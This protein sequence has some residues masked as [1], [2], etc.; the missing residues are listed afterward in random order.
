MKAKPRKPKTAKK[1]P[2]AADGHAAIEDWIKHVKADMRPIA[3]RV[4]ELV[5]RTIPGL[6]YAI[7]WRVPFYGLPEQGWII[8]IA[9][10]TSHVDVTFFGGADFDPPPPHGPV[11]RRDRYVKVKTLEE[12]QGPLMRKWIKQAGRVRGWVMRVHEAKTRLP[13]RSNRGSATRH[14][15]AR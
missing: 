2:G 3:Q 12:A 7:K 10:Y 15:T 14:A 4:D 9:A 8:A 6:Q 1:A 11:R 5:R 13:R